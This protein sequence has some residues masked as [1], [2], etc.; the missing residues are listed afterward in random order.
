MG[1]SVFDAIQRAIEL[2]RARLF[3]F[4]LDKWLTLGFVAFLAGLADGGYNFGSPVTR[5][6]TGLPTPRDLNEALAE[7]ERWV[8]QYGTWIPLGA[9]AFLLV[10]VT[11][12]AL[13]TWVASRGDFMFVEAVVHD[14]A[15]VTEPW[16][17]LREPAWHVFKVRFFVGLAFGVVSLLLIGGAV[18]LTW[19]ELRAARYATAALRGLPFFLS[20]VVIGGVVSVFLA[21]L[22]DFLVPIVYLDGGTVPEAWRS[23][24][25]SCVPG[26]VGALVVFYVAKIALSMVAGIV[27]VLATCLTCCL[28]ALPYVSSVVLLPVHVF[29]RAYSLYMLEQLGRP[30]FPDATAYEPWR[31]QGFPG[32]R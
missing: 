31:N 28:A 30:V 27:A 25:A 22:R 23:F 24:R 10:A 14:R 11:V 1:A 17:R 20:L 8:H 9:A 4:N 19:P 3:P 15:A 7:I 12:S 29:F 16:A 21:I 26:N 32:A 6:R 5:I 13:L 2:T 18:L